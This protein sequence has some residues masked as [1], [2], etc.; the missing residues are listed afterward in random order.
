M[1]LKTFTHSFK[2]H[3]CLLIRKFLVFKKN[4]HNWKNCSLN[5]AVTI[6]NSGFTRDDKHMKI[7]F[8]WTMQ[9]IKILFKSILVSV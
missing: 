6:F 5:K 1:F 7:Y 9:I 4:A 3:N 2:D 8:T